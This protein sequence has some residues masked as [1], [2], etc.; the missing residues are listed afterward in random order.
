[1]DD[2]SGG[3]VRPRDAK[4]SDGEARRG[5][6]GRKA[7]HVLLVEDDDVI[8]EIAACGADEPLGDSVL[9]GIASRDLLWFDAHVADRGEDLV[10]VLGVAVED[11]VARCLVVGERLAVVAEER[12]PALTR[13]W[14]D[15]TP[16]HE[17]GDG[18][19]GDDEAEFLD[20]AVNAWRAP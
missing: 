13:R 15:W 1:M 4:R 7:L 14:I 3:S 9:P 11:Q 8:E 17:A 16:G 10:A 19:L 18:A 6:A 12:S 2:L 20:L 5:E